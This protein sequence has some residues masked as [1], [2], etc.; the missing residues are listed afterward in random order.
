MIFD[1]ET[2]GLQATKIHCLSSKCKDTFTSYDDMRI[3]FNTAKE[4]IG[5][6]IIRYDLPTAERILGISITCPRVVDTLAL[7]WYLFPDRQAHGLESWGEHYG[8]RKISIDDW[9]SLDISDYIARCER[10]VEINQLLWEDQW[11]ILLKL[12]GSEEEAWRL[13]DYLSF[14]MQCAALQEDSRWKLDTDRCQSGIDQLTALKEQKI[15]DLKAIMPP[16]PVMKKRKRPAKPYK[17]DGSWSSHGQS[18]FNLLRDKGL[19]ETTKEV[20]VQDGFKEPNP[21]SSDQIKSLLFSMGWQPDEYKFIKEDDGT[22]RQI[23]QV[24]TKKPGEW[25]LSLSVKSLVEREPR[26]EPL[27][28]LSV[29]SHRL[30]ILEG[31]MSNKDDD[32]YIKAEIQGLTN[33]LRFKHAVAVNLPKPSVPY[34]ELVRGCLIAPSEDHELCGADMSSLEDMTKRHYMYKFDPEYVEEMSKPG[35]DPH[36]D[37]ALQEGVITVEEVAAYVS[38][39]EATIKRFKSV[40]H[41]YKTT[42]YSAT[43]G[44]GG[45]KI[46]LAAG[47]PRERGYQLH[48]TYWKRN[49]AI[50]AIAD[51]CT[52]KVTNG[53]MW[54]F[55]PVSKLWYSLRAEKD[56]FSTLNQGTGVFCFDTWLGN[57]LK[58]RKQ[59]TAQFHDEGVWAIR[60]GH[61]EQCSKLLQDALEETNEQL[62]LNVT[63]AIGIAYGDN[64]AE[65]H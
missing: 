51:E 60:K 11:K 54:L 5:H 41:A 27:D 46:A 17:Q 12:Y 16:I 31:F 32:G 37:L 40:R 35:F 53:M 38:G 25:G 49:W 64:Y 7:S 45:A 29:V 59:L 65:V 6:N 18:W 44:A 61:R 52:I 48:E 55:N 15:A 1:I 26:L 23:P 57:V 63:L 33:T 43:Y 21:N 30:S 10:D 14:K 34:G 58:R 24:N 36:L 8:V 28:G 4:L 20:E 62:N 9:K 3:Y 19:P 47:L 2:D 42:N 39:D 13:I 56:K 22:T 50:K